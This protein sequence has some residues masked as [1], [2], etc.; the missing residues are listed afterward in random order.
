MT[1]LR[2]NTPLASVLLREPTVIPVV[3]RFGIDLGVGNHTIEQLCELHG[4][5]CDFVLAILNTI[6]ND[7]YFP[8]NLLRSY[9]LR[10]I[11]GYLTLADT[12]CLTTLIP[13]AHAHFMRLMA[14]VGEGSNM[15][16]VRDM[17]DKTLAALD[18]AL[19][20]ELTLLSCIKACEFALPAASVSTVKTHVDT[21]RDCWTEV[22][23]LASMLVTLATGPMDANLLY[24][25]VIAVGALEKD[26]RQNNRLR[27]LILLPLLGSQPQA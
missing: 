3:N 4:L 24:A 9:G 2:R 27:S 15:P 17:A 23:D 13:N 14:T 20:S 19:S 10:E 25:V 5:D 26:I 22:A 8:E 18:S 11:V 12:H 1:L 7:S 16:M 6:V 21:L